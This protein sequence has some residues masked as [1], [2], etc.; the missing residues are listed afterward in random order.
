MPRASSRLTAWLLRALFGRAR[1][2]AILGDVS[3]EFMRRRAD[4]HAPLWA[5]GWRERRALGYMS[6]E[7]FAAM[8]PAIRSL[9]HVFRDALRSLRG[10]TATNG[11]IILILALG[12]SAATV[13]F[14][15]VDTVVLRRL[16]FPTS[17]ALV[18]LRLA[19]SGG[20]VFSTDEYLAW[21][22]ASGAF[23]GL[24]AY[25]AGSI[26]LPAA[27]GG[28]TIVS[29]SV[30]ATLFHTLQVHPV[31][32][33]LLSPDDEAPGRDAVAVI[34]YGLASR[35]FGSAAA[36]VGQ[37]LAT[38]SKTLTVVGVMP[39][40]FT[41]PLDLSMPVEIWTPLDVTSERYQTRGGFA[42]YFQLVGR[43]EPGSSPERVESVLDAASGPLRDAHPGSADN[44]PPRVMPLYD[45]L[46]GD[47]RGWMLLVLSAVG[48]VM[49]V[50]CANV[51]NLLLARATLRARE[52][53]VRASLGAGRR[54]LVAGL[55]V[56]SVLLSIAAGAVGVLVATWGIGAAKLALP[57]GIARAYDIA[58]D[59]RVLG[60]ALFASLLTGL[61][62]GAVPAWQ[63]SRTDLIALLKDS[64]ST[65]AGGRRGWRSAFVVFEVAFVGVLLVATTLVVTSFVNVTRADIGFARDRLIATDPVRLTGSIEESIDVLRQVPGVAAVSAMSGGSPPLIGRGFGGGSAQTRLDR[66]DLGPN[67]P[68]L[69]AEVRR[70]SDSY[71]A[72]VG[73]SIAHGTGFGD[74]ADG[75]I[76]IDD[77][78]ARKLFPGRE[79]VGATVRVA[80]EPHLVAGV[81]SNVHLDG[82]EAE[83]GPQVYMPLF[84]RG[85]TGPNPQ[86]GGSAQFVIK[87]SASA[88]SV[89]PAIQAALGRLTPPRP[90]RPS[91]VMI[92]DEAFRRITSDR[93]FNAGLMGLCGALA[94][95]IGLAGVYGV[96][97]SIVAQQT[98]EIGVRV[99][100][101]A[102]A[103]QI[104]RDVVVRATK[105]LAAGL[106]IGL[107]AARFVSRAFGTLYYGVTPDSL[108]IY[109][110][111]AAVLVAAGLLA[112]ALPARRAARIDPIVAL[113]E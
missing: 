58:L 19:K 18:V 10:A 56:E 49:L 84:R 5:W 70:V 39:R 72:T 20:S 76:L 12:I 29:A 90:G 110:L 25:T 67:A 54:R 91:R 103:A 106:L 73:I 57:S 23:A 28:G 15:V 21:R 108:F 7:S 9:G 3:E 107:P 51:A 6:A 55:M 22:D 59:G 53:S 27:S 61:V 81:V 105:Y 80:G 50:A 109:L 52:M 46:V 34:S 104:R 38:S 102:T 77:I 100:L 75:S 101:G 97:A 93:R 112:A 60:T 48:L 63:A 85:S 113:R 26:E 64:G 89:V 16:P 43:L 32:G 47:V 31:A 79:A 35:L 2:E 40:G 14:S 69:P 111:V 92:L 82:P 78:A 36:A 44:W 1:A 62:F 45:S 99:A 71:F 65:T 95:F 24:G 87:T 94:L 88:A 41:Y 83:S 13:T 66:P 74:A 68:F 42:R 98:R 4:G 33:Q 37:P 86:V 8:P 30:T 11:F 17:D 96:M